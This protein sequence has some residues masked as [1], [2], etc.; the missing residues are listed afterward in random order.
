MDKLKEPWPGK[1]LWPACNKIKPKWRVALR[2]VERSEG[3]NAHVVEAD[4]LRTPVSVPLLQ[5][6]LSTPANV[7]DQSCNRQWFLPR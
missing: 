7:T 6:L 2:I 5:N 3:T 4:R 1:G